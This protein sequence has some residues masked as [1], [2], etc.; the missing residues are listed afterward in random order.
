MELKLGSGSG[1]RLLRSSPYR[2][3]VQRHVVEGRSLL[4]RVELHHRTYAERGGLHAHAEPTNPFPVAVAHR[5]AER[6]R[7]FQNIRG[8]ALTVVVNQ[9]VGLVSAAPSCLAEIDANG[10][11]ARFDRVVDVFTKRRGGRVVTHIS[12][13]LD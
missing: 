6:G 1:T 12:K 7:D 13:R 11:R 2:V 8:H 9:D 3:G 10:R 4:P 5:A